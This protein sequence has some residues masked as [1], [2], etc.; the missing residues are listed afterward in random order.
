MKNDYRLHD[1]ELVAIAYNREL[2]YKGVM[3]TKGSGLSLS[4][5]AY[6]GVRS[7]TIIF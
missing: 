2:A 7:F 5:H 1:A 6:K 3:P 4:Y